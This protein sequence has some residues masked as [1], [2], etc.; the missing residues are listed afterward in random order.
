MISTDSIPDSS[1]VAYRQT[2]IAHWDAVARKKDS[3]RSMGGWYHRRLGEI[4]SF[5]VSQNMSVLELGCGTGNLLSAL[6]LKRGMGVDFSSEMI[7][8]AKEKHRS[9]EFIQA[10]AHDLSAIKETFDAIILS[11]LVN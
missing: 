9:I 10:D 7:R 5:H 3:W 8:Q 11:D 4:Y 1:S 2:R 6:N